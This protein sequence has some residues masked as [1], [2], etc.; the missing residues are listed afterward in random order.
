MAT[1]VSY[2]SFADGEDDKLVERIGDEKLHLDLRFDVPPQ[3]A[4]DYFKRKKV[5]K[6]KDFEKLEREAKAA[7]FTVGGIY[8]EDILEAF[9]TEISDALES[10]QTQKTVIKKFKAIL[11]GA[12]HK[13]LGDFHLENIARSNMMMAY[14][15]GQRR[16]MEE[17]AEDLPYWELVAVGD[18]R[19]RPKHL[20]LSGSVYPANHEFW[21]THYPPYDF[22]CRCNVRAIF[23]YPKDYNHLRPNNDTLVSYDDKGLPAKAEYL[24]Q[25]VD[26]KATK[27]VGVPKMASLEK[28]LTDASQRGVENRKRK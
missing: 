27:F 16:A 22:M 15:V 14:G 19:T 21:D 18:D 3:E 20:A 24:T 12:G 17:V 8:K 6:K 4:I 11:D 10:G 28:A 1:Y 25:V 9:K 2:V 5:L 13:M 26:L 7:S 23:N